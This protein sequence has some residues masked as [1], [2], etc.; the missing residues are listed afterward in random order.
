[1]KSGHPL[2][3]AVDGYSSCGKSTFARMIARELGFVYIDSGAMYRA[4]ALYAI[5]HKMVRDNRIEYDMLRL[6]LDRI[7]IR[8]S[9]HP[10]TGNQETWLNGTNVE[11]QIRRIAVSEIVSKISQVAEVRNKMVSMQRK[12]GGD[13][14]VVMDGRDI[15]STVFPEAIL[16]IFMTADPV[17]RAQR[18]YNELSGKGVAVELDEV[19]RNIRMRDFEDENRDVSPLRKAEDAFILDNSNMTVVQQMEWFRE[20]WNAIKV[21]HEH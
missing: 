17:V 7:E 14:N 10:V 9:I 16:K 18:R 11:E 8:F 1:M 5:E 2:I 13:G 6:S 15:G 19:I 21:R 3:I 4:V 20:K 12:I